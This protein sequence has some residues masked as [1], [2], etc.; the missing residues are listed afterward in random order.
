MST[1]TIAPPIDTATVYTY[2]VFM[3]VTLSI[4]DELVER[5]RRLAASQGTSL[6]QM[7]RTLLQEATAASSREVLLE[8][9]EALWAESRGSSG[10]RTWTREELYDRPVLR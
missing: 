8:E 5:A 9:L 10:G 6:N 3:N 7:I 4:E 1:G 2:Y